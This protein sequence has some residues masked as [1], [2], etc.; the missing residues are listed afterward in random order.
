M[1]KAGFSVRFC[2]VAIDGGAEQRETGQ[3]GGRAEQRQ[4][5]KSSE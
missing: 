2:S 4:R 1:F 5:E 3:G